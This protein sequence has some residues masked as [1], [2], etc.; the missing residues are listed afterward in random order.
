MVIFEN[1]Y[2]PS[3]E[4]KIECVFTFEVKQYCKFVVYDVDGPDNMQV[5]AMTHMCV[6]P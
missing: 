2:S 1:V 4:T 5:C 3:F 6:F